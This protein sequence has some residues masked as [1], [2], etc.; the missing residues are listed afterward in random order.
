ML[1]YSESQVQCNFKVVKK[2]M[3]EIAVAINGA[4]YVAAADLVTIIPA[5]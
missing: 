2:G 5:L 1:F 4:Q 3:Y